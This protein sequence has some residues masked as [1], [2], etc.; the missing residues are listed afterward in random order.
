MA[1]ARQKEMKVSITVVATKTF[2]AG[3]LELSKKVDMKSR[4]PSGGLAEPYEDSTGTLWH[5]TTPGRTRRHGA[6]NCFGSLLLGRNMSLGHSLVPAQSVLV[7]ETPCVA[8]S[9]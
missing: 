2:T 4:G 3:R 7:Q 6:A 5:S 1:A 9:Q 8:H